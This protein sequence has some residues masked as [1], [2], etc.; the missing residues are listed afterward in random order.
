MEGQDDNPATWI[1]HSGQTTEQRIQGRE[2][3][4]NGYTE[5]LEDTAESKIELVFGHA[6]Q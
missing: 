3:V 2:F 1:E 5:G 6:R 4:V